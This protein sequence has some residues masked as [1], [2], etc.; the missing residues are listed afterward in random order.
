MHSV[1]SAKEI[2]KFRHHPEDIA[3]PSELNV[4]VCPT[5]QKKGS[6]QRPHRAQTLSMPLAFGAHPCHFYKAPTQP[7]V[8]KDCVFRN[9]LYGTGWHLGKGSLGRLSVGT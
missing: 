8:V 2:F 6:K 5:P 1:M 9:V 7:T 4:T 3:P